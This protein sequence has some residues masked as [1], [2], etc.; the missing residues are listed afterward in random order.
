MLSTRM[1]GF[2]PTLIAAAFAGLFGVSMARLM[3]SLVGLPEQIANFTITKSSCFC[4]TNK[5][6]MPDS[7]QPI[8]CDRQLVYRTLRKWYSSKPVPCE[9]S[10][11]AQVDPLDV[12]DTYIRSQL[13]K[14]LY[15]QIGKAGFPLREV[16]F[17]MT[18]QL[19][20]VLDIL[21]SISSLSMRAFL[22]YFVEQSAL[23]CWLGLHLSQSWDVCCEVTC[24][25]K[26]QN[27]Q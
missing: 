27:G 26:R 5:H 11:D 19:W 25:Y 21:P 14:D 6:R 1:P 22:Q 13:S 7:G 8:L 18:P 4:C 2:V 20:Y 16:L 17:A 23:L 24:S 3:R 12:V 10:C 9:I 15:R